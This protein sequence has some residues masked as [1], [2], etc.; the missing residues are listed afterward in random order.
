MNYI[1]GEGEGAEKNEEA[2]G[3]L[4]D[5]LGDGVV[6]DGELATKEWVATEEEDELNPGK[7]DSQCCDNFECVHVGIMFQSKCCDCQQQDNPL[8]PNISVNANDLISVYTNQFS[9]SDIYCLLN[10][11]TCQIS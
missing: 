3:C 10:A 1:E 8:K 5:P 4:D 6:H 11:A 2:Y 9:I 7:A